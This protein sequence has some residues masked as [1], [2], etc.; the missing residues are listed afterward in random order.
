MSDVAAAMLRPLLR[1]LTHPAESGKRGEIRTEIEP[2]LSDLHRKTP[3][4]EETDGPTS[5]AT[6]N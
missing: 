3:V 5:D 4:P 6:D 1:L 2:W